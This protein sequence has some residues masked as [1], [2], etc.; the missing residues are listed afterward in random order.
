MRVAISNLVSLLFHGCVIGY[1]YCSFDTPPVAWMQDQ[2]RATIQLQASL[3]SQ[4]ASELEEMEAVVAAIEPQ[5][6]EIEDPVEPALQ[7]E[8][9]PATTPRVDA[10]AL[11]IE[12]S[13]S[14]PLARPLKVVRH[15][16]TSTMESLVRE[17]PRQR[18]NPLEEVA[19]IDAA[20]S[21][22]SQAVEGTDV[23]RPPTT[24]PR[25]PTP[26]Y[27]PEARAAGVQ[28]RVVLRVVVSASGTVAGARIETSSGSAAL[29]RS[30]LATVQLWRF[31]PARR[32]GVAVDYEV[33]V[34]V[35]FEI[36]GY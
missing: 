15:E 24:S 35:K 6:V 5:P 12:R 31:E 16:P 29:D 8:P 3:A 14:R 20:A 23:D 17:L 21:P 30:A 18:R 11:T 13:A 22:W 36:R 28:G 7:D 1:L 27:P 2:G 26:V 19:A 25:N 32:G 34:P 9:R 4:A 10:K 33:L